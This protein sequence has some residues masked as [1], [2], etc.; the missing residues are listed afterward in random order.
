[1]AKG[2]VGKKTRLRKRRKQ[3][4][5]RIPPSHSLSLSLHSIAKKYH[6]QQQQQK[7]LNLRKVKKRVDRESPV[8]STRKKKKSRARFE[9]VRI[10]PSLSPTLSLHSIANN[11]TNNRN[12]TL[13]RHHHHLRLLPP[14]C[15]RRLKR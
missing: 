11:N 4:H 14:P 8:K 10:P 1:M 2:G 3:P 15:R 13:Q 9:K 5:V 7:S 6:N 12:R